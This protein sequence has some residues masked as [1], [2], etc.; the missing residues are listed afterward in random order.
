MKN[1]SKF[2]L[3]C[4]LLSVAALG[5]HVQA[6]ALPFDETFTHPTVGDITYGDIS[7]PYGDFISYSLP[8][9][10]Y[11]Y[12]YE[13]GGG[14]GPGN[15][16]YVA[17][18]PGA[19]MNQVVVATGSSGTDVT[20]NID[21]I[22]NAYATPNNNKLTTFTTGTF[23]DPVNTT[24]ANP[25]GDQAGTWDADLAA[26]TAFLDGGNLLWMFNNNETDKDNNQDILVWALVTV[27][28]S[29]DPGKAAIQYEFTNGTTDGLFTDPS[30]YVLS[31]GDVC[32]NAAG[33]LVPCSEAHVELI[34]HN[35]GA[36]QVAYA[37]T[38]PKL[39]DFLND[40]VAGAESTL[41]YDTLSLD[42]RLEGIS[43][44]YEQLF[45]I[46]S[47]T[48]IPPP[49]PIPEPSTLLLLGSGLV[50]LGLIGYRR[51]K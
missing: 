22:E 41:G 45:I 21:G 30:E 47:E 51:R 44:G 9:L 38:A 36:N 12:D 16:F 42:F 35:L 39:N 6:Q 4:L 29:A 2:L 37:V 20:T 28:S 32:V 50:G 31:G 25:V 34:P 17:S 40:W 46:S 26:L 49:P 15:P 14:T 3:V 43:N 7:L 13:N 18:T 19:I 1:V 5:I 48:E 27:W 11:W 10:A 24:T 8:V 23:P 33:F